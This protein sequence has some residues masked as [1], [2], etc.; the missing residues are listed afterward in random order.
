MAAELGQYMRHACIAAVAALSLCVASVAWAHGYKKN[1]IEIVHPWVME[2]AAA[3]G[4]VY[5]KIVN[6]AAG[7]DRLL[8]VT[9]P[10]ADKATLESPDGGGQAAASDGLVV[11]GK[12]ELVLKS[13]G[14][15]IALGGLKKPL[16]A[17]GRVPMS[18][19]FEH[20]GVLAIEVMVEADE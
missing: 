7:S 6:E 9:S 16:N 17:Y 18:L 5:M 19:T 8:A 10:L 15:H 14:P 1:G 4:N 12:G 20:A 11:P 3:D 13:A 2:T